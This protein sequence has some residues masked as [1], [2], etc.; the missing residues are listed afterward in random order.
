MLEIDI[1]N[2]SLNVNLPNKNVIKFSRMLNNCEYNDS[3]IKFNESSQG[4]INIK[5]KNYE[6]LIKK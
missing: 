2:D 3:N 5:N 1:Y 4:K 6:M